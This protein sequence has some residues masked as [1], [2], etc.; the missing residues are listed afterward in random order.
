MV[1]GALWLQIWA[2]KQR[3]IVLEIGLLD[4]MLLSHR[5]DCCVSVTTPPEEVG[6]EETL[7]TK[8]DMMNEWNTTNYGF[9]SKPPPSAIS[10][11]LLIYYSISSP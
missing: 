10:R 9:T 1:I 3:F 6:Q 4:G 2:G 8:P 11:P 5:C 7:Y